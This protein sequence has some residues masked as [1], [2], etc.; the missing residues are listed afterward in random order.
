MSLLPSNIY[1]AIQTNESTIV[2][3]VLT[4]FPVD[5]NPCNMRSPL[6]MAMDVRKVL[7]TGAELRQ[8]SFV[9]KHLLDWGANPFKP[10]PVTGVSPY[11]EAQRYGMC[12]NMHSILRLFD[13]YKFRKFY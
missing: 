8:N 1:A 3:H 2:Q 11:Q 6:S 13:T 5:L 7:E 4:S 12:Y 9:F 10:N